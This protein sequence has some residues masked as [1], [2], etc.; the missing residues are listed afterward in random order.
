MRDRKNNGFPKM[1]MPSSPECVNMLL[2]VQR[3]LCSCE[4]QGLAPWDADDPGLARWDQLSPVNPQKWRAFARCG[5]RKMWRWKSQRDA[6][7]LDDEDEGV[8]S[9]GMRA[10]SERWKR[11]GSGFSPRASRKES[12]PA[13]TLILVQRDPFHTSEPQKCKRVNEDYLSHRQVD[14]NLL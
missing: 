2:I 14:G 13:D 7:V 12:N 8:I 6:V 11:Q 4:I 1:S 10:A 5:Q 3:G 9:Q